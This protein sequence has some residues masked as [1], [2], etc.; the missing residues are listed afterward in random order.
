MALFLHPPCSTHEML[1]AV[2]PIQTLG[3]HADDHHTVNHTD[4]DGL[5][6]ETSF[7]SD[8]LHG[9]LAFTPSPTS[10]MG[11]DISPWSE[12]GSDTDRKSSTPRPRMGKHERRELS[13]LRTT[14][15]AP[16]ISTQPTRHFVASERRVL[17][18][19]LASCIDNQGSSYIAS[20]PNRIRPGVHVLPNGRQSSTWL[21]LRPRTLSDER[22]EALAT[23]HVMDSREARESYR[24]ERLALV[25]TLATSSIEPALYSG[26]HRIARLLA[27]MNEAAKRA[28]QSL[29]RANEAVIKAGQCST[30]SSLL[31][32]ERRIFK[33]VPPILKCSL[34]GR[35]A[36]EPEHI[37]EHMTYRYRSGN[38]W[39]PLDLLSPDHSACVLDPKARPAAAPGAAV[40]TSPSPCCCSYNCSYLSS[41]QAS[42]SSSA[43]AAAAA[44]GHRHASTRGGAEMH[45]SRA[46]QS[47]DEAS[48]STAM[49]AQPAL[50]EKAETDREVTTLETLPCLASP[51]RLAK[52]YGVYGIQT[53]LGAALNCSRSQRLTTVRDH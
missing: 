4:M 47:R 10:L 27:N 8:F 7:T 38:G 35:T 36:A 16:G 32:R 51:P 3:L 25:H 29:A 14:V 33:P 21:R 37:T 30:A 20:A 19:G 28:D 6:E 12:F 42:S 34:S 13:P 15:S 11:D 22:V 1:H 26:E 41:S 24:R 40:P 53:S 2:G 43:A 48:S 18:Y 23:L 52:L 17:P 31:R 45:S 9:A 49:E 44:S 50:H 5:L 39:R 46:Y